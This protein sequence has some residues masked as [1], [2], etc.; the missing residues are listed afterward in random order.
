M[1]NG[2]SE[3]KTEQYIGQVGLRVRDMTMREKLDSRKAHLEE[4]LKLINGAL[5]ALDENPQIDKALDALSKV[6]NLI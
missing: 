1:L 2:I 4:Q 6:G 3:C 5:S